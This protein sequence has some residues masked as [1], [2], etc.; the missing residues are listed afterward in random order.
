MSIETFL[1]FE[2]LIRLATR[3]GLFDVVVN[4]NQR[5]NPIAV[6]TKQKKTQ[7]KYVALL[8]GG[9]VCSDCLKKLIRFK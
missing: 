5:I 9:A 4:I 8:A 7:T 3:I 6:S 2:W 1:H